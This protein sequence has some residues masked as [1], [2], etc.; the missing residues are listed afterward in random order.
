MDAAQ[1]LRHFLAAGSTSGVG[2]ECGRPSA[3]SPAP[4]P[5]GIRAFPGHARV[6]RGRGGRAGCTGGR[7]GAAGGGVPAS[8][9]PPAGGT[10]RPK[11]CCAAQPQRD[12]RAAA[13]LTAACMPIRP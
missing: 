1:P 5:A 8:L 2:A 3:G 6:L 12:R 13:A 10:P 9:G 4:Q 11:G 7:G